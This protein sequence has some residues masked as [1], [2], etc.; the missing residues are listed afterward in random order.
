MY[1]RIKNALHVWFV[2]NLYNLRNFITGG[3]SQW[4]YYTSS[5][6]K[7]IANN[8]VKNMQLGDHAKILDL[9][10]GSGG[11]LVY[12]NK[13]N[14]NFKL[15]G[16]DINSLSISQAQKNLP[17]ASFYASSCDDLH[18]L[19]NDTI[20]A[21]IIF[22]VLNYLTVEQV[23]KTIHE[24]IRVSK[25]GGQILILNNYEEKHHNKKSWGTYP[26]PDNYWESLTHD[27]ALDIQYLDMEEFCAVRKYE[28]NAVKISLRQTTTEG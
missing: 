15:Y 9:G 2:F 17:S 11:M 14:T 16:V 19:E 25:R 24:V 4:L 26:L 6:Y 22:G 21:C 28:G 10:C 3:N 12:L 8:L 5:D 27:V 1:K 23:E 7:Q 18:F 20:D 13:I